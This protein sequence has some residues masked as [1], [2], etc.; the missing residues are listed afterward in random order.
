MNLITS[1]NIFDE[2]EFQISEPSKDMIYTSKSF[3]IIRISLKKDL[4]IKPHKVNH[5]VFFLVLKGKG[6]FMSDSGEIEL[7][8]DDYISLILL[9]FQNVVIFLLLQQLCL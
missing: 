8:K 9:E 2:Q 5:V 3:K 7:S 6:L 4:E 1:K